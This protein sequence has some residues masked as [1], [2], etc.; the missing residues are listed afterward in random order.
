AQNLAP[1]Q[2]ERLWK[3]GKPNPAM[4]AGMVREYR[5]KFPDKAIITNLEQ[6]DGW[7]FAAAGGSFPKLPAKTDER[8]LAALARMTPI[9]D[10]A[11]GRWTLGEA[12][13]QYFVFSL[14]G[15]NIAVNVGDTSGEFTVHHVDLRDGKVTAE[16][17][18]VTPSN[19]VIVIP[20]P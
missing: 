14:K 7:A 2:S 16:E 3:G 17:Q 13:K 4:L 18:K 9:K 20:F 11:E 1:R 12:G 5:E 6:G 15:E 19:G 8:L 10:A